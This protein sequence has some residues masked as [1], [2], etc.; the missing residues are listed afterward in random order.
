MTSDY[1]GAKFLKCD[2]Q[3]Q[4]PADK[5][6]WIGEDFDVQADPDTAA[7]AFIDRCYSVGLEVIAITDHNF[8]SKDFIPFLKAQAKAQATDYELKIF[9]GFEFTA[10]V[11]KG[12]HVLAVFEQDKDLN[13]IDHILTECGVP[14]KR[15]EANGA[16]LPSDKSLS[17]ILEIVQETH[18]GIVILPHIQSNDGI[19]DNEK[20]SSWLQAAEFRNENLLAVEIPKSTKKMS[21]GFQRL[22]RNGDDCHEGWKRVRP[23]A[24]VMSSDC[25]TLH[26]NENTPN[27]IGC[28]FTWIRMSKPSIESL[29][30][31]FLDEESRIRICDEYADCPD[32]SITHPY[33]SGIEVSGALF[34]ADLEISFSPHLNAIIGGRGT[35]KSSILEYLRIALGRSAEVHRDLQEDFDSLRRT[36]ED[37]GGVSAAYCKGSMQDG[38]CW[39]LF[40]A[41]GGNP[42]I[43]P[44]EDVGRIDRFFP[45]RIYSRGQIEAIA[46][47]P[48]RQRLILDDLNQ[49]ELLKLQ[50]MENDIL[51]QLNAMN[52][53]IQK[54][55]KL[56]DEESELVA[57]ALDLEARIKKV[58]DKAKP[59][60][61]WSDWSKEKRASDSYHKEFQEY[62]D[63][64]DDVSEELPIEF[65][66]YEENTSNAEQVRATAKFYF[67]LSNELKSALSSLVESFAQK[68]SEFQ[69]SDAFATWS[70][71]LETAEATYEQAL[72]SL[73]AEG[74]EPSEHKRNIELL[75][76]CNTRLASVREKLDEVETQRAE[77]RKIVGEELSKIWDQQFQ[78]RV[79]SANTLNQNVP[80]TSVGT[81]TV[82][83]KVIKH[84]DMA[85]FIA[86]MQ[87]IQ[88]DKRRVSIADWNAVL[89]AAF[90]KSTKDQ[91][92]PV[93]ILEEWIA[94]YENDEETILGYPEDVAVSKLEAISSWLPEETINKCL[95]VRVPDAVSISLRRR[96]DGNKVG[97]LAGRT[98]SAGQKSTTV[99]SLILAAGSE[100]IVIDQPEDDLDNEFVYEQLVPVLRARKEARQII[101]VS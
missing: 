35:G 64:I 24:K 34:L 6:H 10:N 14:P 49:G 60:N 98:L 76:S 101:V 69:E 3:M 51:S 39:E 30:Q 15:Q 52:S 9:P 44:D 55:E 42:S 41:E 61:N 59:L 92:S 87:H 11:G 5:A 43:S 81:P 77:I 8:A 28:R 89:E 38:Q 33:I 93:L 63:E 31:A 16:H 13:E 2:L 20:I 54:A 71:N 86:Q 37:G 90:N 12:V 21:E 19:F 66:A 84:G 22:F 62:V 18:R 65:E 68:S 83:C 1:F 72:K 32:L 53:G 25:K 36:L 75:E 74:V 7:K 82:D 57:Q 67:D 94:A 97:E 47:D 26:P 23:V 99:L 85:A 100:P 46:N 95:F 48:E 79:S 27:H 80:A 56:R 58:R 45:A 29:R 96:E 91:R 4:T 17:D 78:V 88:E 40:S 50:G 73:E 70:K